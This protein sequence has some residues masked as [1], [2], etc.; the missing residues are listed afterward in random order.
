MKDF[1]FFVTFIFLLCVFS[2]EEFA[3]F[4]IINLSNL[5]K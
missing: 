4:V 2:S 5:L 1:L 3:D